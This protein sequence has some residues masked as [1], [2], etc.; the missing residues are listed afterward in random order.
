V[1]NELEKIKDLDFLLIRVDAGIHTDIQKVLNID[2]NPRVFIVYKD[3][4]EVWRK[5][6]LCVSKRRIGWRSLQ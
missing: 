2:P 3:G 5:P 6:G 1:I 4:K